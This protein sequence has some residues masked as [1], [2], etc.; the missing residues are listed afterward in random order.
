MSHIIVFLLSLTHGKL[1]NTLCAYIPLT[2]LRMRL[3][4]RDAAQTFIPARG[5][6]TQ[7]RP[8]SVNSLLLQKCVTIQTIPQYV[9]F[10][11]S[12]TFSVAE[13]RCIN[14]RPTCHMFNSEKSRWLSSGKILSV[15]LSE[16]CRSWNCNRTHTVPLIGGEMYLNC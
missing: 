16:V 13:Y 4:A 2:G 1:P 5:V 9:L 8:C 6:Y 14:L 12:T 10:L 15:H 3:R 7:V 11:D